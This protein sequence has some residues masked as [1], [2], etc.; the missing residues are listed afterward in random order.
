MD[1]KHYGKLDAAYEQMFNMK[2]F[3]NKL[4]SELVSNEEFF[5]YLKR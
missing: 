4:Q 2:K 3:H 5:K 1:L